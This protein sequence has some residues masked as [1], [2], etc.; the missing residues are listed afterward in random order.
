MKCAQKVA[1]SFSSSQI[2]KPKGKGM[3]CLMFSFPCMWTPDKHGFSFIS[4]SNQENEKLMTKAKNMSLQ[5]RSW[6]PLHAFR[7][8]EASVEFHMPSESLPLM[9]TEPKKLQEV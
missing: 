6:V 4:T 9:V 1:V 3:C 7:I 8:T 2:L 5:S